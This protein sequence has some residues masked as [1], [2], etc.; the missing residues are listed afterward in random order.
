MSPTPPQ[1]LHSSGS[2]EVSPVPRTRLVPVGVAVAICSVVVLEIV[3]WFLVR[4]QGIAFTGDSPSYLITARALG[5]LTFN[6]MTAYAGDM[7]SHAIYHWPHGSTIRMPGAVHIYLPGP[8]GPVFAQGIGLP[9]LLAPF[10][11]AGSVT[12]ALIGYFALI[13]S[14]YVL[15]HQRAS[16]LAG[17]GRRGQVV[18]ALALAAPATWLAATQVYPDLLSGVFL[19]CAFV[20]MGLFEREGRLSGFGTAVVS[21]GLGLPPWLHVKNVLPVTIGLVCFG[22][23]ATRRRVPSGRILGVVAVVLASVG[24]LVLYNQYYFGHP[25]GLPAQGTALGVASAWRMGA[26]LVDRHQGL[27]VQVPTALLGIVGLWWSRRR[28][29]VSVVGVALTLVGVLVVNGSYASA[30]FGGLSFAG[31][32]QWTLAPVLLAWSAVVVRRLEAFPRRMV[33]LG[34]AI[35]ALWCV[36]WF[37]IVRGEHQYFSAGVPPVRPWDPALYPG[38]WDGI[39]RLLPTLVYPRNTLTG[40]DAHLIVL[41]AALVVGLWLTTRLCRPQPIR[42]RPVVILAAGVVGVIGVVA[43]SGPALARPAAPLTWS[44]RLL[45][46]PWTTGAVPAFYTPIPLATVG[47]GTF[48]ATVRYQLEPTS[49]VLSPPSA[50]VS[51]FTVPMRRAVVSHWLVPGDPTG[52]QSLVVRT[53]PASGTGGRAHLVHLPPAGATARSTITFASSGPRNLSFLLALP[54]YSQVDDLTLTLTKRTS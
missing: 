8:H 1:E 30:P 31:R 19:A 46:G 9:A 15:L 13:A 28:M 29:P 24:S 35:I 53:P 6:P 34:A 10:L 7:A 33:A 25:E 48:E 17:L 26:L 3:V 39:D 47:S 21:I 2:R 18:F 38:W 12:L 22:A 4:S 52:A 14:G 27:L 42:L 49:S 37:P 40:T 36:Q 50:V 20:E 54:P 45:G 16:R 41:G 51:L 32:F 5:H 11:A 43:A 44:T 23:I